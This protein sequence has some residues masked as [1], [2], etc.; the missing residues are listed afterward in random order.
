[1]LARKRGNYKMKIEVTKTI[2]PTYQSFENLSEQDQKCL[3]KPPYGKFKWNY[4]KGDDEISMLEIYDDLDDMGTEIGR[5]KKIKTVFEVLQIKP[6]LCGKL[7]PGLIKRFNTF[8]E[9]DK[10][11]KG[12]LE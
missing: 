7:I 5:K 6:I 11:I 10:F 12:V 4:K 9:A 3:S 2:H 1:M 8:E